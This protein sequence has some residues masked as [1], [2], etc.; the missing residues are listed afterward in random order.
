[1]ASRPFLQGILS[2]LYDML[3]VVNRT[4]KHKINTNFYPSFVLSF[5]A[6]VFASAFPVNSSK[7]P[8]QPF[9]ILDQNDFFL[10]IVGWPLQ[11]SF[12]IPYYSILIP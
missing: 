1:M 12:V 10:P 11:D 9:L 3:I 2:V 6:I 4:K 5:D 8:V 7:T